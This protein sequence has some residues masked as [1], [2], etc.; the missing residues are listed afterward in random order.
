MPCVCRHSLTL[1]T[2]SGV[3]SFTLAAHSAVLIC[4]DMSVRCNGHNLC[5]R[6]RAGPAAS[7]QSS[8][9]CC[10][11]Q[12][13]VSALLLMLQNTLHNILAVQHVR[14]W[15]GRLQAV[16]LLAGNPWLLKPLRTHLGESARLGFVMATMA[17]PSVVLMPGE[18]CVVV[19]EQSASPCSSG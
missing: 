6:S 4:T 11:T 14:A 13:C 3:L 16:D 12:I 17:K 5:K 15:Q 19:C 7:P 18:A 9:L 2:F 10:E 1:S 8:H